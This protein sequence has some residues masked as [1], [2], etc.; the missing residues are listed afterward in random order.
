MNLSRRNAWDA[1]SSDLELGNH[2]SI[3]L[4]TE[5]NEENICRDGQSRDFL[6]AH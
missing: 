3:C 4:K 2:L 6:D 5:E 1:C